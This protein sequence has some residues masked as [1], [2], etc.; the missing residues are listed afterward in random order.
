MIIWLN[1]A[2]GAGK[3][4]TATELAS[5]MPGA[6]ICDPEIVGYLLMEYLKDRD[7]RD[8]QDGIDFFADSLELAGAIQLRDPVTQ[9]VIGQ[10]PLPTS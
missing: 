4:T 3:T 5:L 9:I 2:F 1:G 10:V 7:L 8:F 6:R